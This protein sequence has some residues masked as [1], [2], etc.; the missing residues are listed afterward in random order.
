LCSEI[1]T[2]KERYEAKLQMEKKLAVSL[3]GENGLMRKRFTGLEKSIDEQKAE[4]RRL[5]EAQDTLYATIA[6]HEKDIHAFKEVACS[7]FS[8]LS[9]ISCI[10]H[11]KLLECMIYHLAKCE[12]HPRDG[13]SQEIKE[14]DST[15]SEKE[16]RIYDLKKKNQE[17]EKF[18]FVLDHKINELK[19]QIEP[20]EEEIADM[21]LQ[22][23]VRST[24]KSMTFG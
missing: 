15:I 7:P 11:G 14:R 23:R 10:A 1:E 8:L 22:I 4:I 2:L 3:K 13:R 18:K 19:K 20:K 12:G 6:T 17:L 16:K 24:L 5:H 9:A 21:K